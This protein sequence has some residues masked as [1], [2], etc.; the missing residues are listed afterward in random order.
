MTSKVLFLVLFSCLSAYGDL[1]EGK[2]LKLAELEQRFQTAIAGMNRP[3]IL[4]EK[5]VITEHNESICFDINLSLRTY[6]LNYTGVKVTIDMGE[7]VGQ[8]EVPFQGRDNNRGHNENARV[9]FRI[10]KAHV[11]KCAIYISGSVGE[12]LAADT[13]GMSS[14]FFSAINLG[15]IL[16]K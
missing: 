7:D 11:L 4:V 2:P 3:G 14:S 8:V 15:K 5:V 12:W 13:P 6:K 10:K 16:R 1:E 9:A